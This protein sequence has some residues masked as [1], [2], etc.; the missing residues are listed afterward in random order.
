[1]RIPKEYTKLSIDELEEN[2]LELALQC[3]TLDLSD[4]LITK[5]INSRSTGSK[6]FSPFQ[7]RYALARHS[8]EKLLTI[9]NTSNKNQFSA[10]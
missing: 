3:I 7:I 9:F 8:A 5:L 10:E 6:Y 2:E 4:S 1:M